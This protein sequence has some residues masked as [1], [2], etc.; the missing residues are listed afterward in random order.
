MSSDEPFGEGILCTK[1]EGQAV[2]LGKIGNLNYYKC[3]DCGMDYAYE[4]KENYEKV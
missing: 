4:H 2:P 3:T 1:C